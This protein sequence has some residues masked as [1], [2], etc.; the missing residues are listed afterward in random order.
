MNFQKL[1]VG[2]HRTVWVVGGDVAFNRAM[3]VRGVMAAG[4]LIANNATINGT[5]IARQLKTK[6]IKYCLPPAPT[7]QGLT[8]CDVM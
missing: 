3:N 8:R 6:H 2:V 7:G 1:T 4:S 5:L